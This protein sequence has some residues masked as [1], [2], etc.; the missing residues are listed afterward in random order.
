MEAGAPQILYVWKF[1]TGFTTLVVN[2]STLDWAYSVEVHYCRI[3]LRAGA[4]WRSG[5]INVTCLSTVT[6]NKAARGVT[7]ASKVWTSLP[8]HNALKL[9]VSMMSASA[10][11]TSF[12]VNYVGR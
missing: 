2:R 1:R 11:R 5:A 6:G 7:G 9:G 10:A 8:A 4:A 12:S 3:R